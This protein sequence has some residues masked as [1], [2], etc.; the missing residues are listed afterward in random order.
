MTRLSGITPSGHAQLGNYLGAIRRWAQHT[1]GEDLYFVSD[2]HAMTSA[3]NPAKLRALT[4]E[5]LAILLGSGIPDELV[6]VQSDLLAEHASLTWILECVCTYGEARRMIQF[7][8]KS[9][10]QSG[11]RLSLLSYPVLMVAD[12][13][14]YG[15]DQVPVGAD[16]AQHVELARTLARRFNSQYGE[17]F[18]VPELQ[19]PTTAERVRDLADPA[20]KM[21]K[22][23]RD[24]AGAIYVLDAP[25][26]IRRKIGRAVTDN[27][28]GVAN[29][30]EI[31]AACTG[32]RP[33]DLTDQ[34]SD[35]ANLKAQVADAVIEELRETRKRAMD[36]IEDRTELDR[37]RARG[38]E[39]AR[40]RAQSRLSA[41]RRMAGLG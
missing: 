37:I 36:L 32:Q 20:R 18:A 34:V 5:T 2:L 26:L 17:V 35:H 29:L 12:I 6:F 23:T 30:V 31:L 1:S 40:E 7:K 33:E 13:L 38:A 41:A 15:A 10:G 24:S 39:R 21:A 25:D 16:Q 3:H 27:P 4:R 22:S 8:E 11:V 19:L 9:K 28:A 14:L